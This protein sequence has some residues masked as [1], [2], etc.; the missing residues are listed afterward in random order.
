LAAVAA[1]CRASSPAQRDLPVACS[2]SIAISGIKLLSCVT[3]E[4]IAE[5]AL[6]DGLISERELRQTVEALY[7][8]AHDPHT[9][10]GGSRVFQAWGRCRSNSRTA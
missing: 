10:I 7:A 6:D 1:M 9:V 2:V 3:L 5:A 4:S 8:F